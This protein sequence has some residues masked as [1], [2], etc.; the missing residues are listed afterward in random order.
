MNLRPRRAAYQYVAA[1]GSNSIGCGW[2]A[3]KEPRDSSWSSSSWGSYRGGTQAGE[4]EELATAAGPAQRRDDS[5]TLCA[6]ATPSCMTPKARCSRGW[7]A[8]GSGSGSSPRSTRGSHRYLDQRDAIKAQLEDLA[9]T[10]RDYGD[11]SILAGRLEE[12]EER[13]ALLERLK[14]KHG[15]TL[16]DVIARRDALAAEHAALTG[17]DRTAAMVEAELGARRRR[18]PRPGARALAGSRVAAG[19][20]PAR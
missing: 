18:I 1:C 5:A 19:T 6:R 15:P 13:L 16:D 17:A 4:D 8:S 12:V 14:R 20:S 10:L 11:R 3:E 7:A 2:T 9:F